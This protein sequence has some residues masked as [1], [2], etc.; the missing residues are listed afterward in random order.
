VK[1]VTELPVVQ[2]PELWV[3]LRSGHGVIATHPSHPVVCIQSSGINGG[4]DICIAGGAPDRV[5]SRK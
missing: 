2:N 3:L 4:Q 1:F 5:V